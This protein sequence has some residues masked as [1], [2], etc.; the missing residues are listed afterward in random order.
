MPHTKDAD[1]ASSTGGQSKRPP[2]N[3]QE[4]DSHSESSGVHSQNQHQQHRRPV[5]HHQRQHTVGHLHHARGPGSKTAPKQPKLSRRHTDTPDQVEQ[6]QLLQRNAAALASNSH[7]RAASDAKLSSRDSSSGNLVK[8]ASQTKLIKNSP[9]PKI[10]KSPSHSKLKRNR[11]HTEIGKRTRSAELKRA[12]S[13]TIVYQPQTSGGKSQVHFDL[14]NEEDEWVDASGS[15]SPYLSRKGSLNS[16]NHSVHPD[17]R[18][19]PVTPNDPSA[20]KQAE[21]EQEE[22]EEE[23]EEEPEQPNSTS[24]ERETAHHK[25]Y[26]TSRILKR[27]PSHGAPPQMTAD[28]AQI[29]PRHFAPASAETPGSGTLAGSNTDELTSRFVEAVGSGLTSD[30]SFYRPRRGDFPRYDETPH[31]ARSITSLKGDLEERREP[32]TS[33]PKQEVDDSALAPKTARRTAPPAAQ[34][35][36]TQQ[37]LNLQRA[38]SVIEPGQAVGGVGGVV[39]HTPLIGVGGPGYDGGNS[40]DPRVGKLLERTG[41]EYLVV[42]RYQNPVSRSLERLN[43][44]PG[45]EKSLRIPRPYSASTNGKRTGDLVMR[46]HTRNVSMPDARRPGTPKRATS[47]R[48]NGAGS[49]YDGNDDDGRLT[50]RL[51]GSSLVGG[52]EEDGTAALLRNLWEKSTELS[53]STD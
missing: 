37:K 11:S 5:R 21:Q 1:S 7:R 22:E 3:H 48:T 53:A 40:R 36:R 24:P 25:E 29:S 12:S 28:L 2:L 17:D 4:S 33:A 14:G 20:F 26:L 30:G 49:S 44:L 6:Q 43:H 9:Q 19:R 46:Q 10:V 15:N 38:S 16:S 32:P 35:S 23:E 13:T 52:E 39:G 18:S 27:T 31:K 45:M 42:R 51:S 8:S 50:D 34:T 47:V 41:M